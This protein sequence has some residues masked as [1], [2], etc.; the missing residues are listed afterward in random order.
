MSAR[1]LHLTTEQA[2]AQAQRDGMYAADS[3]ATDGFIHCSEPQQLIWVANM[4]FRHRQDLVLLQIDLSRL[5]APVRYEN[6]EGGEQLFPHIYG[7]LNL[8]AVLRATPF[9]PNAD[10]GFDHDQLGALY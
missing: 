5:A 3:L 4:R 8:D 1:I 9:P 6:L 2:W 7:A 10:G